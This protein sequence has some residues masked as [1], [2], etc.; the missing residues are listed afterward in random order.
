MLPYSRMCN[1]R[2][3]HLNL[4]AVGWQAEYPSVYLIT[5]LSF[6]TLTVRNNIPCPD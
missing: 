4:H 3:Y 5:L 1:S 6:G 2:D